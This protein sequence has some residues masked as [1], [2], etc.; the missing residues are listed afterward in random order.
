M[1]QDTEEDAFDFVRRVSYSTISGPPNVRREFFQ[2]LIK[3]LK[4]EF[5]ILCQ[6]KVWIPVLLCA[7]MQYVHKVCTNIAYYLH[8]Q[9]PMLR[10]IGFELLPALPQSEQ[11][12]SEVFFFILFTT[13]GIV[14]L[15]PL[16][17]F[18]P[19]KKRLSSVLILKRYLLTIS[20]AF[21]FRCLSFLA[22]ILPGPNYH[23]RPGSDAYHPPKTA[24]DIFFNLDP[25]LGCGD[26]IFS[27]HTTFS[28]GAV[29]LVLFYTKHIVLKIFIVAVLL[30]MACLVIAARKHYSVDVVVALYVVPLI[31]HWVKSFHSDE[32]DPELVSRAGLP[33]YS[34]LHSR[35]GSE[36]R[37]VVVAPAPEIAV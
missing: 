19:H 27:S 7:F 4:L 12:W 36:A 37:A 9:R 29:M 10:D 21:V 31:F 15:A 32:I 33:P 13:A 34:A 22:T 11:F 14:V 25:F 26:L 20:I 1:S 24:A 35:S 23:C 16:F 18:S 6:K 5:L 8:E 17:G 28:T 30:T 2:N 3:H